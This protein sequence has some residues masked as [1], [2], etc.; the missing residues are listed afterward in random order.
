MANNISR[1]MCLSMLNELYNQY[2]EYACISGVEGFRRQWD[3]LV[4]YCL[5]KRTLLCSSRFDQCFEKTISIADHEVTFHF[6]IDAIDSII[7]N[8][9]LP[10]TV[11]LSKFEENINVLRTDNIIY[12]KVDRENTLNHI[13][14]APIFIA[15]IPTNPIVKGYVIDGNHRVT[16]AINNNALNIQSYFI[17]EAITFVSL[18]YPFDK[19]LF[20]YLCD[21]S[22]ISK[23]GTPFCR[24]NRF[25]FF[26]EYIQKL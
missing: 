7:K 24:K 13:S 12:H 1:I 15:N 3:E 19:A 8:N 2:K 5:N 14:S 26:K 18:M 4:L 11:P 22:D 25:R 9:F 17:D 21:I 20:L 23:C 16:A 6:D 10:V